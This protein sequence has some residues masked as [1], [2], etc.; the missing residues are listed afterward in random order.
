MW[1]MLSVDL[2]KLC[3]LV[4]CDSVSDGIDFFLWMDVLAEKFDNLIL[5]RLILVLFLTTM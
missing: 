5:R 3:T 2:E 4:F 1:F